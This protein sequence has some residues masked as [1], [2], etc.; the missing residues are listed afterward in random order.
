MLVQQRAVDYKTKYETE[1][2]AERYI[3]SINLSH[4]LNAQ[5]KCN[6]HCWFPFKKHL[7]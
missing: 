3:K 7:D 5:F 6:V 4:N 1:I 2:D